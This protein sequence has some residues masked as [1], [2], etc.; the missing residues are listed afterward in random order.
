MNFTKSIKFFYRQVRGVSSQVGKKPKNHYASLG[1]SAK[2][3]QS[4]IKAAY[5]KLSMIY[6]P[7]KNKD[8]AA[9]EKFRDISEAYETLSNVQSRKFYDRG[10]NFAYLFDKTLI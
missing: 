4:D 7:D 6:H 5:Y 3:T 10:I 1:V 9:E 2:A 8:S